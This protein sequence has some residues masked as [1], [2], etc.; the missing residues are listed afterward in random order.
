MS[1]RSRQDA[2]SGKS[3]SNRDLRNANKTSSEH[4]ITLDNGAAGWLE[5][6]LAQINVFQDELEDENA[7]LSVLEEGEQDLNG[8]GDLSDQQ[9]TWWT[10]KVR[11]FSRI[12]RR[13]RRA[14]RK[15]VKSQAFYWIVIIL[16]FLNTV[17]LLGHSTF[18]YQRAFSLKPLSS[19]YS[20]LNENS[21]VK[22]LG[23]R[24]ESSSP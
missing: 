2:S 13:F 1:G 3:G 10:S 23:H 8:S 19:E 11:E 9:P 16:V 24:A 6:Q 18:K 5:L 22:R 4:F 15:G 7:V 17:S 14:C 20:Q 12:N 21:R